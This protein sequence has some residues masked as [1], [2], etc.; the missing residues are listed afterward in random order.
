MEW[1]DDAKDC[2]VLKGLDRNE[3]QRVFGQ[4]NFHVKAFAKS[5]SVAAQG[6]D[7][8]YFMILLKGSVRG[9]ITDYSGRVVRIEDVKAPRPIAGA[10]LFGKSNKFPV[11]VI[12]NEDVRI[13][14]IYHEEFL[15][16]LSLNSDILRNYL[17]LV[18]SRAQFLSNKIRFLSYKS[19]KCKI[20]HYLSGLKSEPGGFINI[21]V[22]QQTLAELFGVARP[23]VARA[24]NELEQAGVIK[25]RNRKVEILDTDG[26]VRLMNE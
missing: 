12:A 23:S 9:E 3:I 15:K 21:P 25:S 13:M 26:L 22:S 10:F 24:L 6:D 4:V 18:S 2:P 14:M 16:L 1:I 5:D 7:V 20:A 8:R 19:I 11:D 17:D